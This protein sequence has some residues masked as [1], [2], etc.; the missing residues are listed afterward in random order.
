[1]NRKAA[2]V[3]QEYGEKQRVLREERDFRLRAIAVRGV[4]RVDLAKATGW[5]RPPCG[6]H[7]P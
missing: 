3:Q 6:Y 2:A 4:L 1:V 7:E 5:A